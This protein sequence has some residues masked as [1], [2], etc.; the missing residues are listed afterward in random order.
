MSKIFKV[1][2]L[3]AL[4]ALVLAVPVFAQDR[5]SAPSSPT[6]TATASVFS[7]D[8][9]DSMDVHWYSD[10]EFD[11]WAGFVSYG[12]DTFYNPVSLGFATSFGDIYLGTWYT[13]NFM[14]ILREETVSAEREYNLITQLPTTKITTTYGLQVRESN[15][16]FQALIGVA[17]MGFKLGFHQHMERWSNPGNTVTVTEDLAG[18]STVTYSGEIDE[19]AR[20]FGVITPSLEW[21]MSIEAGSVT[22]RPKV[23][24]LFS[25]HR[26]NGIFNIRPD[27]TTV[28]GSLTGN[29]VLYRDGHSYNFFAPEF[30]VGAGIGLPASEN[31]SATIGI[32]YGVGF[33]VFNN[34][35]DNSGF[36]GSV[37]GT[38]SWWADR[39]VTRNLENTV[40]S[41]YAELDIT[42]LSFSNHV[43]TPSFYYTNQVAEGL[44]LGLY[45]ELP[46]TIG[47][48]TS[49]SYS[50]SF[51]TESV[52]FNHAE[53]AF[54]NTTTNVTSLGANEL[55]DTNTFNIAANIS[56]GATYALVPGRFTVNAG[57]NLTPFD[58][59]RRVTRIS[60]PSSNGIWTTTVLDA[61]GNVISQDVST[62][63]SDSVFDEVNSVDTWLPFA[64]SAAG[65]F[66]LN[67]TEKM[68]ID[69]VA[70]SSPNNWF[71]LTLANVNVLFRVKF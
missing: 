14:G 50:N 18:G 3:F 8:V 6:E 52:R 16:Q 26:D 46:F 7:T 45:S 24:A 47:R 43:I 34:S 36:S 59:T 11:K 51:Y 63:T 25:F 15:N 37:D 48:V 69:M 9:E 65:G 66:T 2:A 41:E 35:Y 4:T 29:E 20:S 27:Y 54:R 38:V 67:F 10:V 32:S 21:G 61:N 22:I 53:N 64:A 70:F 62:G 39:T 23:S 12:G 5:Q 17:G 58:Y 42:D 71:N 60:E 57:V 55:V 30:T 44:T 49:D 56:L 1:A 28:N 40:T 68:A 13:G 31:V 33:G 19:F